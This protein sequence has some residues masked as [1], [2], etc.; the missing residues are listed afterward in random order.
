[1]ILL[2]IAC[3]P[4]VDPLLGTE[5]SCSHSTAVLTCVI[6]FLC[7]CKAIAMG[8]AGIIAGGGFE[9]DYN[10]TR[11]FVSISQKERHVFIKND[12]I[13]ESY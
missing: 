8:A 5:F 11:V 6:I 4:Y 7:V 10:Y 13:Q 12:M 2:V 9:K 3:Y 1:M